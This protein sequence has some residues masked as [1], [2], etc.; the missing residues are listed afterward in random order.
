MNILEH[1]YHAGYSI[2]K[3]WALAAQK[4]LPYP[5][6]SIG[7]LTLGGTG[8]T[9]AAISLAKQAV[10]RGYQPVILTRGYR[11]R[12]K[13]PCFVTKCK[14]E[15]ITDNCCDTVARAGDEPMLITVKV[16]DAYVVKCADRY[17]G[18][19]FFL[20]NYELAAMSHHPLFILDDGFQHWKLHR[21]IDVVLVDGRR[22]FGNC[23]MLPLGPMRGPLSE[24]ADADFFIIT[25]SGNHEIE[26]ELHKINPSAPAYA[27]EYVMGAISNKNSYQL[28][29]DELKKTTVLAF[30]G[31]ADPESFRSSV[32]SLCPN[33]ASFIPF[34]DHHAYTQ[35]DVER[36]LGAAAASGCDAILTTEKDMVKLLGLD[37]PD[38]IF[39]LNIDFSVGAGF[40]ENIFSRIKA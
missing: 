7:N 3:K 31:L 34:R 12:A 21:D 27:A 35:K 19:L 40:Y 16:P 17:K 30:C 22:G 8:K 32:L 25:K 36:I 20:E 28:S 26:A 11:G 18:G 15:F 24:L 10:S 33:L 29:I 9:P 13:G 2:K 5:V 6:I 4:K 1:I 38:Y 39:S 23:R 37:I 14:D